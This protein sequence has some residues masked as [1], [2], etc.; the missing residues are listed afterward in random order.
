MRQQGPKK[1][2]SQ[3]NVLF[4]LETIQ[5]HSKTVKTHLTLARCITSASF[6]EDD[7][8]YQS[9]HTQTLYLSYFF[10]RPKLRNSA[11]SFHRLSSSIFTCSSFV[12]VCPSRIVTSPQYLHFI[13]FQTIQTIHFLKALGPRISKL[14]L[15]SVA[16][17][18]TQIQIH[19]YTNT[20]Y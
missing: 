7:F 4:Y 6:G 14:I 9:C 5:K 1:T 11:S 13:M 2:P 19:K 18:N 8:I 10:H 12:V 17:T 15:P 16:Y 20:A 3:K